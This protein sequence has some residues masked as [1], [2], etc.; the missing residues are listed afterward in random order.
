MSCTAPDGTLVGTRLPS[1]KTAG[2][3]LL[4]APLLSMPGGSKMLKSWLLMARLMAVA[5]M[6]KRVSGDFEGKP[7]HAWSQSRTQCKLNTA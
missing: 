5:R 7:R 1:C 2:K 3:K 6:F 4:L